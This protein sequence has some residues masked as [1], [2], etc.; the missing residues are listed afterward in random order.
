LTYSSTPYN[1]LLQPMCCCNAVPL[2]EHSIS[3][4]PY[5][6]V[7]WLPTAAKS[8]SSERGSSPSSKLLGALTHFHHLH[9][10][11]RRQALF[12]AT[13][14]VHLTPPKIRYRNGSRATRQLNIQRRK[15]ESPQ[16]T[17]KLLRLTLRPAAL[18]RRPLS[19]LCLFFPL[20]SA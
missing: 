9:C 20:S 4:N 14:F 18:G 8:R 17:P 13:T 6:L 7:L 3:S 2:R 11:L 5:H 10:P 15:Q 12:P 16:H 1:G 19:P